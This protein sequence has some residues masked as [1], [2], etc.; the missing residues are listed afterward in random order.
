MM[1]SE[2]MLIE[3]YMNRP[4][5]IEEIEEEISIDEDEE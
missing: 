1:P 2:L 5:S 4:E 3:Y